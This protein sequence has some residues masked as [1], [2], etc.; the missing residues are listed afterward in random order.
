QVLDHDPVQ[1]DVRAFL[2]AFR[3]QLERRGRSV[4]GITTDGSPLYP[5]VIKELWPAARHQLC[6]FHVLKEITKAILHALAKFRKE[7]TAQIPRQRRG[8]PRKERQGEGWLMAYRRRC[9]TELFE[10]RYLFVR[11][12]LCPPQRKQLQKLM[13]GRRALRTL[14]KIMEAVHRLFDR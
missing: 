7:R 4:S 1:D 3:G 6:E 5:K 11:H 14:R 2:A 13:Y 12:H 9:V 10:Q 8:G